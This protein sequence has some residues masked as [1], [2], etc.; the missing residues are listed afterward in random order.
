M[1]S[2]MVCSAS[3]QFECGLNAYCVGEMMSCWIRWVMSCW[4]MMVSSSFAMIG[5]RDIGL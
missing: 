3:V 1:L 2:I 5:R 4:L